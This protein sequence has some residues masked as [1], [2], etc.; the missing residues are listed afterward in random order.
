MRPQGRDSSGGCGCRAI[1]QTPTP[2]NLQDLA[3]K[4][5]CLQLHRENRAGIV[6]KRGGKVFYLGKCESKSGEGR[7]ATTSSATLSA[8]SHEQ[9]TALI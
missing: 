6:K 2:C 9:H 3:L 4:G 8:R 7:C 5:A 1:S